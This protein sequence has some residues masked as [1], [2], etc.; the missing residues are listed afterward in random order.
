MHDRVIQ[1]AYQAGEMNA[2]VNRF[3]IA[4]KDEVATTA[5]ESGLPASL[6]WSIIRQESAFNAH[7]VSSVGAKGLM[8]L[9]PATAHEVASGLDVTD[10]QPDLFD[11]AVNIRLG[12]LYLGKMVQ[13]FDANHAIAAAA[14][15]AG[16]HRVAKW[17][18]RRAFDEPDIWIETIPYAETRRYVQQVMAFTVVY[19]WR[20][21]KQPTG[22]VSQLGPAE[23][24]PNI[25]G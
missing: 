3:P 23:P 10:G 6:I 14:Y 5:R 8:Q 4:F 16:P 17:L 1:A 21:S 25:E 24:T 18:E 9:M 7:A 12:S 13:Q 2:L 22:I 11:P 20:Q 15:N 19:D